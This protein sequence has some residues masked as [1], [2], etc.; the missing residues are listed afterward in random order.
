MTEHTQN[1]V[2]SGPSVPARTGQIA[3]M[4]CHLLLVGHFKKC[5]PNCDSDHLPDESNTADFPTCT[6]GGRR[7]MAAGPCIQ[8][9]EV[10]RCLSIHVATALRTKDVIDQGEILS[11]RLA[12]Q[13]EVIRE[14]ANP[15]Q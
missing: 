1:P 15:D 4:N 8:V 5:A 9:M 12:Y 3:A 6:Q 13:I 11:S 10:G 14:N 7:R 2:A